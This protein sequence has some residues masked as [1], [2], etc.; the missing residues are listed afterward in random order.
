VGQWNGVSAQVYAHQHMLK[1]FKAQL[2]S[3]AF[4]EPEHVFN[5]V[6]NRLLVA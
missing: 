1:A 4:A 5:F 6:S 2:P 3:F